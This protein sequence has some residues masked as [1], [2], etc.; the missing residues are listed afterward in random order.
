M[1]KRKKNETGESVAK[2]RGRKS[3]AA[4]AKRKVENRKKC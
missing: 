4:R 2:K 1:K 3:S